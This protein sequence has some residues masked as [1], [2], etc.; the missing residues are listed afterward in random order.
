MHVTY[1]TGVT[2]MTS[3]LLLYLPLL[4]HFLIIFHDSPI[5]SIYFAMLFPIII[6]FFP[7]HSQL[8]LSSFVLVFILCVSSF[9]VLFP[10]NSD[11]GLLFP[12]LPFLTFLWWSVA[13]VWVLQTQRAAPTLWD[14]V[15]PRPFG[16][17][18]LGG[19]EA[20]I[21]TLNKNIWF[22]P[23]LPSSSPSKR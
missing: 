15:L 16:G 17:P 19:G 2:M 6:L 11:W 22:W 12:V 7:A 14:G 8:L 20:G 23:A 10:L 5:I 1:P 9:F 18:T 3:S 13:L 4:L 21:R